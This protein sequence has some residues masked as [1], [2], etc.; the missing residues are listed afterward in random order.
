MPTVVYRRLSSEY[1][2]V[3]GQGQ[4]DF[5]ADIYAVAQA[6][7]TRLNLWLGE[8]WADLNDGLPMLQG[9]LGVM[10]A[11][12]GNYAELLIQERILGTPYVGSLSNVSSTY[13]P[14]TRALTFS[15]QTNVVFG[16]IIQIVGTYNPTQSNSQ[17]WTA[18][19]VGG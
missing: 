3:Y 1:E 6:I 17:A 13:N 19:P 4:N 14:A 12:Q 8:W 7:Q 9:I 16:G 11:G 18:I 10:G 2:P 5:V 15:C